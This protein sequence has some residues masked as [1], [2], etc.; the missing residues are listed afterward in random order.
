M[1]E[2]EMTLPI[3]KEHFIKCTRKYLLHHFNDVLISQ[4]RRN[5]YERMP[6][7]P[8]L[9]DAIILASDNSAVMDGHSQD[10]LSQATQLHSTQLVILS[11]YLKMGYLRHLRILSGTTKEHRN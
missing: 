3:F 4:G 6:T 11:P 2:V 10:Q 7:D 5:L 9:S 8:N 1:E